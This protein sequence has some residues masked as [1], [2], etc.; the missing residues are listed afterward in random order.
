MSEKIWARVDAPHDIQSMRDEMRD[1]VGP[2]LWD[3][4]KFGLYAVQSI[5][6]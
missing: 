5:S 6:R 2:D 3:V 4:K 1:K